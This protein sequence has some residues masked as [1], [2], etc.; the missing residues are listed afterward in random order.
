[1]ARGEGPQTEK[2]SLGIAP[3]ADLTA[4]LPYTFWH[5]NSASSNDDHLCVIF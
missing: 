4:L 2:R 1:M 3:L 5:Q